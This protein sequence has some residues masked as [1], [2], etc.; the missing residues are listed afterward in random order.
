M[1]IKSISLSR[2]VDLEQCIRKFPVSTRLFVAGPSGSGKS[3]F[4]FNI[5]SDPAQYFERPPDRIFYY[6][7]TRPHKDFEKLMLGGKVEFRDS[8]PEELVKEL[9]KS[10]QADQHTLVCIDDGLNYSENS[11]KTQLTTLFNRIS[12]HCSVSLIFCSQIVLG[13][14]TSVLRQIFLN[15]N[16]FALFPSMNDK[17]VARAMSS[18]LFSNSKFIPSA[19]NQLKSESPFTPLIILTRPVVLSDDMR[20]FSGLLSGE[21]HLSSA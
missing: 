3:T 21:N 10:G 5:L 15:C 19:L 12:N 7:K 11:S 4:L 2:P 20:V 6:Y 13:G 8:H 16:A 14:S 1:V 9:E 17:N 18:R